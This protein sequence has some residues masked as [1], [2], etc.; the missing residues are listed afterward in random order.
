[1]ARL[2]EVL[3]LIH[4]SPRRFRTARATGSSGGTAWRLWWAGDG[5][6]RF[7]SDREGGYVGVRAGRV[8]WALAGGEA[9]T[10]D[11]DPNSLLGMPPEIAL[12][13]TRSLL[14]AAVLEP[15]R[16]TRVAGRAAVVVRAAPR[17][18][19][20]NWRWWGFWGAT[21]P[22]EVPID[23][24]RG[25]ALAGP[26]FQVDTIAFDEAFPASA[27]A[28]PGPEPLWRAHRGRDQPRELP[29]EE[30]RRAVP[31]PVLLP[32]WLPDGARLLRCLVDPADPPAWIGLSWAI[33]PGFQFT[34][35]L[36]Q[37]PAVAA[38]AARAQRSDRAQ[39]IVQEGVRLLVD[40]SGAEH[41]RSWRVLLE[42]RGAWVEVDSDLALPTLIRVARSLGEAGEAEVAAP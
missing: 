10:N 11:G 38:D 40:E 34:L 31:F 26:G 15:L 6:F 22:I 39:T 41:Y 33:D 27:F 20:E 12:L 9:N 16:E 30:G 5:H 29:L 37:G 21:D 18:G 23:L 13:H 35:H 36:R 7:E 19:A 14:A 32:G 8:W 24:E 4:S 25:V 1:M 28:R 3:E 2:G 17:P 42:R